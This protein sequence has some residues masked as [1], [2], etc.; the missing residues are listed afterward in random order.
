[1]KLV[2]EKHKKPIE[3][4]KKA[5]RQLEDEQERD[6]QAALDGKD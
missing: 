3:L 1:V 4:A 6:V 2:K 5:L